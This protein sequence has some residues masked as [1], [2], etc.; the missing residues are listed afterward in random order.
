MRLEQL[1]YIIEIADTGS[2]T[3]ASSRLFIAQP[4]IS[5]AVTALEKELNVTIF[6]R[7]RLGAE[8]TDI[9]KKIIAHARAA[10]NQISEI[11][12][13]GETNFA[14]IHDTIHV[15]TVPTLCSTILP[16]AVFLFKKTFPNVKLIIQE[17]GSKKIRQ[18]VQNGTSDFG[19][20]TRH[21][22]GTYDESEQFQLLFEG[23]LM[24]YVGKNS[25]LAL[26]KT[27]TYQELAA[28][29]VVIFGDSFSLTDHII[30][31]L[32][33]YGTPMIL[34]STQNPESMQKLVMATDAI[35][36]GPDV[37]LVDNPYVLNGDIIPLHIAEKE[38]TQFGILTNPNRN[39][40]TACEALMKELLLQADHFERIHLKMI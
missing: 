1:K 33:A 24:A 35:G 29:P 40:S 13:L 39:T 11:T 2:F 17:N 6:K 22:Y 23:K 26:E 3:T 18:N 4:S 20:V 34:S 15:S 7:S 14:D 27:A 36:F 38:T 28:Y 30:K 10:L 21:D 32:S 25:P 9:G 8:P 19:L 16:T 12:K 5:Q 31:R 37:Y